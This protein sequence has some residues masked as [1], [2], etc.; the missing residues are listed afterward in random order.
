MNK[1][2]NNLIFIFNLFLEHQCRLKPKRFF[3]PF[4]YK[5]ASILRKFR[6]EGALVRLEDA[7]SADLELN[8]SPSEICILLFLYTNN[9]DDF[10]LQIN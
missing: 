8:Y 2:L 9:L 6:L 1:D 4:Y 7:C 5:Q 10:L 3:T